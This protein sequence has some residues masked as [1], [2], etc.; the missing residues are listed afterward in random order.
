MSDSRP[1][2]S[3]VRRMM[4]S[5]AHV[6]PARPDGSNPAAVR[7]FHLMDSVRDRLHRRRGQWPVTT[8]AYA[9]GDPDSSVAVCVLTSE[10]LYPPLAQVSGVAIAGRLTVPNLGIETILTN[11]LANPSIRH[12]LICGVDSPVFHAG[13]ALTQLIID[14]VDDDHRIVGARGHLP[15]LANVPRADID[16]FRAQITL[17][18]HAGMIDLDAI[19]NLVRD[20]AIAPTAPM[21]TPRPRL[22]P[23]PTFTPLHPGGQREPIAYDPRGFFVVETDAAQRRITVLHYL[24]DNTPG[25]TIS[26]RSAEAVLLGLLDAGLVSQLTHAG[27]LGAELTKAETALRLGIGYRQ[28]QPLRP[29]EG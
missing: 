5:L 27:Y 23:E 18:D 25:H 26:G 1:G 11:T 29:S 19:G 8:G 24:P 10:E 2:S 3:R 6:L 4:R 22:Q 7:V 28:D 14:G 16:S 9:V 20:L 21:E 15:I 13:E 12:L 17:A